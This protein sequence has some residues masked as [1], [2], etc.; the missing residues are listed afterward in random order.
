MKNLAIHYLLILIPI[1]FLMAIP[2]STYSDWFVLLLLLYAFPYRMATDGMRLIQMGAIKKREI[3][4]LLL[5]GQ[6][7]I[8]FRKLY[9]EK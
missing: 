4:K 2:Y 5:P 8:Y 3:W 6:R 9:L 1:P 7:I